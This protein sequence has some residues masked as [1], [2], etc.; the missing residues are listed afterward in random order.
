LRYECKQCEELKLQEKA[1]GSSNSLSSPSSYRGRSRNADGKDKKN[2]PKSLKCH[3]CDGHA[4][5]HLDCSHNICA[6]C[7]Q[8]IIVLPRIPCETCGQLFTRNDRDQVRK[9]YPHFS[10]NL[11]NYH[12]DVED[13]EDEEGGN[14]VVGTGVD[15]FEPLEE[16]RDLNSADAMLS[17][18]RSDLII[19]AL[20]RVPTKA[21]KRRKRSQKNIQPIREEV[22]LDD[23]SPGERVENQ[24]DGRK[25]ESTGSAEEE[26]WSSIFS[27]MFN[28]ASSSSQE[29]IQDIQEKVA[30]NKS[31]KQTCKIC[32][33]SIE[34]IKNE[35]FQLGCRC[36]YHLTCILGP[37]GQDFRNGGICLNTEVHGR[38]KFSRGELEM[39]G[40]QDK[41]K[42]C[43]LCEEKPFILEL[44]CGHK[45]CPKCHQSSKK[46]CQLCALENSD[47][48][49]DDGVD[50]DDVR[51]DDE[52]PWAGIRE[53]VI[54]KKKNQE[55]KDHELARQ[56]SMQ[57]NE[58]AKVIKIDCSICLESFDV[59]QVRTLGCD[60]RFCEG[61]LSGYV[62]TLIE[63]SQVSET[64]F[65]C[66][67]PECKTTLDMFVVEDLIPSALKDRLDSQIIHQSGALFT[68][69]N[70]SCK[71]V[72]DIGSRE[73]KAVRCIKC[74]KAYCPKC[75][76]APH[77]DVSCSIM[78]REVRIEESRERKQPLMP[79]PQCYELYEK[80][81]EGCDHVKCPACRIDFCF[82]C[83]CLRSPTLAHG[84]HYHRP[85]CRFFT[86][87]DKGDERDEQC[88]KCQEVNGVCE[89]PD[90]L[91]NGMHIPEF[92][93]KEK[94]LLQKK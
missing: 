56:L 87:Y 94:K 36:F 32:E 18:N 26:G 68:C 27:G 67:N 11:M 14:V 53:A 58:D 44:P 28:F 90:D 41:V 74:R 57:I 78:E 25:K 13:D 2:V 50:S 52:V 72:F 17:R 47:E 16:P 66:P 83:S 71:E 35:G 91:I 19:G 1:A 46:I 20:D 8:R 3:S 86:E 42:L 29:E 63:N 10:E 79:C 33:N 34:N 70:Q 31:W 59:S 24:Q 85:S 15:D 37:V 75:L 81:E 92:Y 49:D 43:Q 12:D 48:D 5:I 7:L 93:E 21:S 73:R 76:Q 51:Q 54:E 89:R 45:L 9:K 30:N 62:K 38:Y 60:H 61:C 65:V 40:H 64:E 77:K 6:S 88:S 69:P 82:S 84:N 22:P 4:E 23:K 80:D 39:M 55:A